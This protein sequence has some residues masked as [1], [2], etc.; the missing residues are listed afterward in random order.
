MSNTE[1]LAAYPIPAWDMNKWPEYPEIRYWSDLTYHPARRP[2]Y[3]FVRPTSSTM[4]Y[5]I[6]TRYPGSRTHA[7]L[8]PDR[9]AESLVRDMEWRK[10]QEYWW[11]LVDRQRTEDSN[12]E[13]HQQRQIGQL[14][15][16]DPPDQEVEHSQQHFIII[17]SYQAALAVV[18]W[19]F[20]FCLI[21]SWAALVGGTLFT[22]VHALTWRQW[23]I[24]TWE[25]RSYSLWS[26]KVL[27]FGSD[28]DASQNAVWV[29]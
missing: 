25:S 19:S 27:R 15:K 24:D 14:I 12:G 18:D 6:V 28:D 13:I 2:F 10:T 1:T 7:V 8:A 5:G 16:E 29:S 17:K 22:F 26:E 20:P 23:G 9:R 11:N 3:P 4:N 21:I